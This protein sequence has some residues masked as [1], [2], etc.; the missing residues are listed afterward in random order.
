M[1]VIDDCRAKCTMTTTL[2]VDA[3][4]THMITNGIIS[5][6]HNPDGLPMPIPGLP[7]R[8]PMTN[9]NPVPMAPYLF[10]ACADSWDELLDVVTC[11]SGRTVRLEYLVP[12]G[13]K[14]DARI[15]MNILKDA[16]LWIYHHQGHEHAGETYRTT[17]MTKSN[18]GGMRNVGNTTIVTHAAL[19]SEHSLDSHLLC[20]NAVIVHE[21]EHNQCG[22]ETTMETPFDMWLNDAYTVDVARRYLAHRFDPTFVRLQQVDSPRHPLLGPLAI[23]D[24]GH[25]GATLRQ[26]FND[27]EELLDAVNYVK[28]A[29]LCTCFGSC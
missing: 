14:D 29:K 18:D 8:K 27:P 28:G 24:G 3:R 22:S 15:P 21:F 26:G 9:H 12:L 1:P 11:P 13:R 20:A 10:I 5:P 23:K 2:E 17:S 19:V 6:R 4:Y 25:A 7:H 16:V